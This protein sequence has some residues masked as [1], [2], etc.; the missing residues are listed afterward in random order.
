MARVPTV[1]IHDPARGRVIIN[2]SDF[3]PTRHRLWEGDG[4]PPPAPE[5]PSIGDDP[6]YRIES[7]GP[8]HSIIGPDGEK[9]GKSHRSEEEARQALS[10]LIA[11]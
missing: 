6:V 5:P 3:D 8:W 9:V 7:R 2:E 4:P 11:E 10:E 1:A